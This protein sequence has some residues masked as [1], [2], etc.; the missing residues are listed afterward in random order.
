MKKTLFILTA[1][2][3]LSLNAQIINTVAGNGTAGSTGDGGQATAAELNGASGVAFDAQGNMY[4][5]DNTNHLI[6]KV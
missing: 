6:R 4:I 3:S 2:F 5:A 1:A